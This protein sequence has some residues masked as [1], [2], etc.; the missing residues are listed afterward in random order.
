MSNPLRIILVLVL[1]A[2]FV[3]LSQ[4]LDRFTQAPTPEPPAA[5]EQKAVPAEPFTPV[6]ADAYPASVPTETPE[7]PYPPVKPTPTPTPEGYQAPSD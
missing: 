7:G 5:S 1:I 3:I 6:P 2:V 4:Q